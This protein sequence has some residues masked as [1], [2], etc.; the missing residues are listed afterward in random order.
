MGLFFKK[1]VNWDVKPIEIKTYNQLRE[2]CEEALK[3]SACNDALCDVDKDSVK[4][5]LLTGDGA[6][7]RKND[8]KCPTCKGLGL[9]R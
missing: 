3:W 1:K 8:S 4:E 6:H 7:N 2:E 9:V 5:F